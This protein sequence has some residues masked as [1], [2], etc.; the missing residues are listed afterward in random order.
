MSQYQPRNSF[1]TYQL[2]LKN[3]ASSCAYNRGLYF[4]DLSG[5]AGEVAIWRAQA[6]TEFQKAICEDKNNEDAKYQLNL[7]KTLY[8]VSGN[9]L[10]DCSGCCHVKNS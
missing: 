5:S 7:L 2:Y 1:W 6:F 9:C 4:M 10:L 3:R 8:D